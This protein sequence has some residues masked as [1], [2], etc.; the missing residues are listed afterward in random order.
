MFTKIGELAAC[1]T[2]RGFPGFTGINK[3][4]LQDA[5]NHFKRRSKEKSRKSNQTE[6]VLRD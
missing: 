2:S 4:N 6:K 5:L 1:I 3:M